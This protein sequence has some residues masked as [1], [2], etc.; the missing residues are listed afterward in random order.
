MPSSLP[1]FFVTMILTLLLIIALAASGTGVSGGILMKERTIKSF[2]S[3]CALSLAVNDISLK[4]SRSVIMPAGTLSESTMTI[5][6]TRFLTMSETIFPSGASSAALT[7]SS[8]IMLETLV[9]T[10]FQNVISLSIIKTD[11]TITKIDNL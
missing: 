3:A 4:S 1:F 11:Y 5:L 7:G 2:A 8:L 6:P 9:K 10:D